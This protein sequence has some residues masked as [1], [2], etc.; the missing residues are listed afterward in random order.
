MIFTFARLSDNCWSVAD[1]TWWYWAILLTCGS[2]TLFYDKGLLPKSILTVIQGN[3]VFIYEC[4]CQMLFL[5]CIDCYGCCH[6]FCTSFN[7]CTVPQ[8]Y[9]SKLL[10]KIF[11]EWIHS[12]PLNSTSSWQVLFIWILPSFWYWCSFVVHH[13]SRWT[14]I[15]MIQLVMGI[16]MCV[17]QILDQYFCRL[18][19]LILPL[20]MITSVSDT[21]AL[22]LNRTNS[23]S[24]IICGCNS[25]LSPEIHGRQFTTLSYKIS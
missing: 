21:P 15:A 6:C 12:W 9:D 25:K 7:P 3:E 1:G 13:Y 18:L 19:W 17:T 22:W 10:F 2:S 11:K 23:K 4:S 14:R 24:W 20:L 8:V 16:T 5:F